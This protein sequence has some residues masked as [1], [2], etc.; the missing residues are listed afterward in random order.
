MKTLLERVKGSP[1]VVQVGRSDTRNDI[2]ISTMALLS[3]HTSRIRDLKFAL[4]GWTGIQRFMDINPGPFPLLDSLSFRST[5]DIRLGPNDITMP[6]SMRFF[7]T[8]VNLRELLF[9]SS[10]DWSPPLSHFVFPNLV[11]FDFMTLELDFH[12]SQFLDFLEA[13]PMLRT[14]RTR[15]NPYTSFN[16]IP[17]ERVVVL[18]NVEILD[19]IVAEGAPCYEIM[20]H[21]SCP[22]I[23]S[24]SLT[25]EEDYD[26]MVVEDIFPTHAVWNTIVQQYA[27]SPLEEVALELN[28]DTPCTLTLRS[29]DATVVRL[30]VLVEAYNETGD[31]LQRE[32]FTEVTTA[33]LKHPQLANVKRFRICHDYGCVVPTFTPHVANEVGRLFRSLGPLDELTIYHSDIRPYFNSILSIIEDHMGKSVILSPIRDLIVSHPKGSSVEECTTAIVGLA[34]ARHAVGVPFERVIIRALSMPA[35]VKEGLRLW[36]GNVEY[37][38]AERHDY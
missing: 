14:V 37:C 38:H 8:A 23:T 20:A 1:L 35:G 5:E 31:E 4:R 30:R 2:P 22:T 15:V 27:R 29:S 3:S 13:S 21:I 16:S 18:P 25:F 24:T 26:A 17:P 32:V 19:I 33:V 12:A 28:N 34:Q 6:P 7:G 11:V 10:S 9:H 36:V